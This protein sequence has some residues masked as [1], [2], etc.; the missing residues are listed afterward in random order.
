MLYFSSDGAVVE[1][2]RA[3]F[4]RCCRGRPLL[5]RICELANSAYAYADGKEHGVLWR[6]ERKRRKPQENIQCSLCRCCARMPVHSIFLRF[7]TAANSIM[8]MSYGS[9]VR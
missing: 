2:F 8:V 9:A 5:S 4:L 3:I 1:I 7:R 6:R